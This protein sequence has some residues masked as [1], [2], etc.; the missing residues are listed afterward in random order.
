[1]AL[2]PE[3]ERWLEDTHARFKTRLTGAT[4]HGRQMSD[5]QALHELLQAAVLATLFP[6]TR[7]RPEEP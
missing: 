6:S 7:A 1:M 2:N 3:T 4:D 5:A